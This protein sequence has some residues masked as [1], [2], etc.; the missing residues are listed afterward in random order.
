MKL[1]EMCE[2]FNITDINNEDSKSLR[3]KYKKLMKVYHPDNM[4]SNKRSDITAV[5]INE[6]FNELLIIVKDIEILKRLEKAASLN[7]VLID[8]NTLIDVLEGKEIKLVN[9]DICTYAYINRNNTYIRVEVSIEVNGL[10]TSFY[11]IQPYNKMNDYSI[12]AEIPVS[13]YKDTVNIRTS[14]YNKNID[15][16]INNSSIYRLI[17]KPYKDIKVALNIKKVLIKKKENTVV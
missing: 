5:D 16:N 11:S 6:A 15:I 12:D 1:I 3:K 17:V 4:R 2:L 10:S 7:T 9:G 14:K 8:L 13:D